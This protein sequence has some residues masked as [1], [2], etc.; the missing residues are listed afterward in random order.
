MILVTCR[1]WNKIKG[2]AASISHELIELPKLEYKDAALLF[3][4]SIPVKDQLKSEHFGLKGVLSNSEIA[5]RLSIADMESPTVKATGRIPGVIKQICKFVYFQ[6]VWNIKHHWDKNELI[7]MIDLVMCKYKMKYEM[8][9][10]SILNRLTDNRDDVV[11]DLHRHFS[12]ASQKWHIDIVY[13]A[14]CIPK[15]V[16]MWK[17]MEKRAAYK[18]QAQFGWTYIVELENKRSRNT[19]IEW[20]KDVVKWKKQLALLFPDKLVRYQHVLYA[21]VEVI[22]RL[23]NPKCRRW[24]FWETEFCI[25]LIKNLC[26]NKNIPTWVI[27]EDIFKDYWKRITGICNV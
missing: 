25:S 27:F 16:E 9:K 10:E 18:E 13:N 11:A 12:P 2:H 19:R 26:L 23:I 24:G 20:A 8:I 4:K 1:D 5:S 17:R 22:R 7:R 6:K 14:V 21:T 3:I 15:D